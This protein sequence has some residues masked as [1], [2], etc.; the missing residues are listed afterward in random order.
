[1]EPD[2][3]LSWRRMVV[4]PRR[5]CQRIVFVHLDGERRVCGAH[6][7]SVFGLTSVVK[8]GTCGSFSLLLD[9]KEA[10]CAY[11]SPSPLP[12]S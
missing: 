2:R 5:E 3:I 4:E 7:H 11:V 9:T 6:V 1:M 8:C 10:E 12:C